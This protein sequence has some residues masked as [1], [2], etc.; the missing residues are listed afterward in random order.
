[1]ST[2]ARIAVAQDRSGWHDRFMSARRQRRDAGLAFDY[3]SVN[4]DVGVKGADAF[5]AHNFVIA[6]ML[7]D[8]PIITAEEITATAACIVEVDINQVP[9]LLAGNY[10]PGTTARPFEDKQTRHIVLS[11][12]ERV[13]PAGFPQGSPGN[14]AHRF[15]ES[16]S[17]FCLSIVEDIKVSVPLQEHTARG[18][19]S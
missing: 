1:M 4:L 16:L 6:S 7:A 18:G 9:S 12:H 15:T 3:A 10:F 17:M 2:R 5:V 14:A 19:H 8:L 11:A 13:V